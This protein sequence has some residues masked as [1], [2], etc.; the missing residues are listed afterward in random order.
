MHLQYLLP[1]GLAP[2]P[3]PPTD[4]NSFL[5]PF[6][7]ELLVLG[8][9]ITTWNSLKCENFFLRAFLLMSIGDMQA[10]KTNQYLR[11]P[12][13]FSPCRACNLQG[14]RD[15]ETHSPNYYYPLRAPEGAVQLD[16]TPAIDWDPHSL[17]L[18]T[19]QGYRDTLMYITEGR[20]QA[21]RELRAKMHGLNGE[22]IF[23]FL[24]SF[25][26]THSCLHESM[27]LIW[28]NVKLSCKELNK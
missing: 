11:G 26:R 19:D 25:S 8:H 21:E 13:A 24:P 2:G 14:C 16:L 7:H 1:L 9:G 12:N 22:S 23:V 5:Y 15:P 27:H 4:H 28:E 17:P 20:T 3:H 18:H 6:T 10:L